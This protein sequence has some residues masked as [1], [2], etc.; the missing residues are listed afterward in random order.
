MFIRAQYNY[1]MDDASKESGLTCKDPSLAQQQFRDESDINTLVERFKLTG[2]IPQ[3]THTP[4]YTDY[5]GIFDFQSAANA[6]R[7][8]QE[9]FASLPAKI[10]ARFQN[11]PQQFHDFFDDPGNLDEA[12]K[13]GLVAKPTPAADNPPAATTPPTGATNETGTAS[14]TPKTTQG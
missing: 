13:L 2:E 3:L 10:R 7:L 6:I 5:E 12:V 1:S 14:P 4:S 8:A 11:D 9:Q